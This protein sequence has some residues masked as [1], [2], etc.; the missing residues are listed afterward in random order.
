M[1]TRKQNAEVLF[2]DEDVRVLSSAEIEMVSRAAL[3]NPSGKARI[4]LH[5]SPDAP[6]HEMLVALRRD[7]RYPPHRQLRSEETHFVLLGQAS[8]L[9][10]REDG[11]LWKRLEL[12]EAGSGR[13]GYSRIPAGVFHCL[14]IESEVCVFLETKLGPFSPEDNEFA[15]FAWKDS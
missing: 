11:G 8:L 10:Y 2:A 1:K 6:L 13:P 3:A 5:R 12:G 7:V 9:L 15:F 14:E 4:C